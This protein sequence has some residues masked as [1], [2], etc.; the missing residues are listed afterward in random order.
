[1]RDIWCPQTSGRRNCNHIPITA[2]AHAAAPSPPNIRHPERSSAA[3]RAAQSK[4]LHFV[5]AFAFAFLSVIPAGNLLLGVP[6]PPN[7]VILTL[8]RP[9]F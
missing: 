8:P 5:L 2:P 9:P 3:F 4:A 1:M 6:F 7:R